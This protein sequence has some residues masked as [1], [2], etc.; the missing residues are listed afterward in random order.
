MIGMKYTMTI[1]AVLQAIGVPSN[2]AQALKMNFGRGSRSNYSIEIDGSFETAFFDPSTSDGSESISDLTLKLSKPKPGD[3][4]TANSVVSVKPNTLYHIYFDKIYSYEGA[5]AVAAIINPSINNNG[6]GHGELYK[7]TD[8]TTTGG[9][10]PRYLSY[11]DQKWINAMLNH[12]YLSQQPFQERTHDFSN[13]KF[14]NMYGTLSPMIF[15]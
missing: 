5:G 7:K 4:S 3:E 2:E 10:S 9:V 13:R 11:V 12:K 15:E 8:F 14:L 6:Q 1:A